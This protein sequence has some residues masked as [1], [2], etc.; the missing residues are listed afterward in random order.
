MGA[1]DRAGLPHMKTPT[2]LGHDV[3]TGGRPATLLAEHEAGSEFGGESGETARGRD[4]NMVNTRRRAV[5]TYGHGLDRHI[6]TDG[7]RTP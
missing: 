5:G 2:A 6:E 3:D 1:V 4:P 7:D